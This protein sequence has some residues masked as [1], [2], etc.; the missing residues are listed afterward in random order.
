MLLLFISTYKGIIAIRNVG[1]IFGREQ[2]CNRFDDSQWSAK[3]LS[4]EEASF[5]V[6]HPPL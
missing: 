5:A 1:G 4:E 3:T 2:E 6:T